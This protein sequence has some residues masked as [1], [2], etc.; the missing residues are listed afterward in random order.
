M[1]RAEKQLLGP[2][3]SL[4]MYS[5][6]RKLHD[7]AL[8]HQRPCEPYALSSQVKHQHKADTG[9]QVLVCVET[10]TLAV[11]IA[12]GA[13]PCQILLAAGLPSCTRLRQANTQ[14]EVPDTCRLY[15]PQLL[16]ARP[17]KETQCELHELSDLG[18]TGFLQ[19]VAQALPAGHVIL[20]PRLASLL[21][22]LHISG[23]LQTADLGF[24][25]ATC[26]HAFAE[27]H[28]HWYLLSVDLVK[29]VQSTGIPCMNAQLRPR[30]N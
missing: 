19:D 5:G 11:A 13:L 12:E 21:P 2:G 30:T 28:D 9:R 18:V 1:I 16:D 26:L 8:L 27:A 25:N 23:H 14:E 4:Q 22:G 20:P 7:D 6:R 3:L 15:G 17:L 24:A 29:D 10:G